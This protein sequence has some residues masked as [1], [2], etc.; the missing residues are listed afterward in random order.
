MKPNQRS[1]KPPPDWQAYTAL[2]LPPRW[3]KPVTL[4]HQPCSLQRCPGARLDFAVGQDRR[5]CTC[6]A[7]CCSPGTVVPRHP[8]ATGHCVAD[9]PHRT[10][11]SIRRRPVHD[12]GP[13]EWRPIPGPSSAGS[14]TERSMY[15]MPA[16]TRRTLRPGDMALVPVCLNK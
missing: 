1:T 11:S 7:V 6:H 5:W 15:S 9:N 12:A 4:V 13:D 10:F 14:D 3:P 8:T 16:R 2:H